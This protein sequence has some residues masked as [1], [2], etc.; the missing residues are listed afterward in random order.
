MQSTEIPGIKYF[1][2]PVLSDRDFSLFGKIILDHCGIR[3]SDT[4]RV[5]LQNRIGKRLRELELDS[6]TEYYKYVTTSAMRQNELINLWS[7][8][9]TNVT[10]F[11]REP[12]HFESLIKHVLP[13]L[14]EKNRLAKVFRIWSAGCSTGQEPYTLAMVLQ[15]YCK[16][17]PG[18]KANIVGSDIDINVLGQA[19][20]GVYPKEH[21][22]EIPAKYF[23]RYFESDKE[24]IK[25]NDHLKRS[26]N[27]RSQ[28]L[29]D[30]SIRVA[31]YDVIFCRN[32]MMYFDRE[33]RKELI[34]FF[35]RSLADGGYLFLGTSESLNG[36]PK[37]FQ[38]EKLGKAIA[39]RKLDAKEVDHEQ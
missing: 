32:V 6:F 2:T 5:L 29:R 13:S 38:M 9:T 34:G 12:H 8:I 11:F 3:I 37:L 4:K 33:F 28:N 26:V 23:L 39:Y 7:A 30:L 27:F 17:S 36:M 21:K 20:S 35:H 10:H 22:K 19:K 16:D 1:R 14:E 31:K 24:T 25:V 15:D 18:W